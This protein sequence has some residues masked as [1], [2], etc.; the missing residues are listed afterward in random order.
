MIPPQ[1][2][3]R[4][5]GLGLLLLG[6][7]AFALAGPGR[8][9]LDRQAMTAVLVDLGPI[10]RVAGF[11]G[12]QVI[13]TAVGVPGTV[14]VVVGGAVFGLVWG[15]LWSVIG[16][17]LGAVV[18]FCLARYCFHSWFARRFSQHRQMIKV[19]QQLCDRALIC[20]LLL[21]LAPISPFNLVNFLLGLTS[22]PLKPY[23]LG[24]LVGITPGTLAYT[25]LGVTGSAALQGDG[26]GALS[27]AICLLLLLSFVPLWLTRRH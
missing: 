21:R 25:W 12:L 11:V 4:R 22:V 7:I 2:P 5:Y 15:T 3:W 24:T 8:V 6:G 20:V 23:A 17:S 10:W 1:L 9:L 18:A 16:A 13:A 27:L 19:N 14:L 26:W